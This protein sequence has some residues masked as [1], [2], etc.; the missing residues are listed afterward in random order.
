MINGMDWG[1]A[2]RMERLIPGGKAFFLAGDHGYFLGPTRK[3]ENPG[4]T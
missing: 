4:K 2:S 1:M 3:H